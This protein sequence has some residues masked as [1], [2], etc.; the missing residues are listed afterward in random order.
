MREKYLDALTRRVIL[1]FDAGVKSW[2][3]GRKRNRRR[4][5]DQWT[6]SR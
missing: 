1:G 5:R 6:I 4:R 2:T 3:P